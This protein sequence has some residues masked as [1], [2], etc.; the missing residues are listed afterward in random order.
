MYPTEM[1]SALTQSALKPGC[2]RGQ[3][4]ADELASQARTSSVSGHKMVL[5]PLTGYQNLAILWPE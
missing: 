1:G 2:D 3:G 4:R 5:R